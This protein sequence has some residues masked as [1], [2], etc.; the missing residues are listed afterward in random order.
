MRVKYLFVDEK[1]HYKLSA[2]V[3]KQNFN[4]PNYPGKYDP[5]TVCRWTIEGPIGSNIFIEFLNINTETADI[6]QVLVGALTEDFAVMK[7]KIFGVKQNVLYNSFNNYMIIKFFSDHTVSDHTVQRRGFTANYWSQE[8]GLSS[9]VE[10]VATNSQQFLLP[11]TFLSQG[12][13]KV[14]LGH[15]DLVWVIQSK[16]R[17][18]IITLEAEKVSLA[19]DDMIIVYDGDSPMGALLATY[20]AEISGPQYVFSTG[21]KLYIIMRTGDSSHSGEI[22]FS[23]KQG[24]DVTY[25]SDS[26]CVSSPGYPNALYANSQSCTWAIKNPN[27]MPATL[28]FE[29]DWDFEER[30][31]T[32]DYLQVFLGEDG[33]RPE[34]SDE[35]FKSS[36]LKNKFSSDD[37]KFFLRFTTNSVVR[38]KGFKACFSIKCP[39]HSFANTRVLSGSYGIDY[40]SKFK[41]SCA[42]GYFFAQEEFFRNTNEVEM[43]CLINGKWNTRVIPQCMPVFCGRPPLIDHGYLKK[44]EGLTYNMEA[45]YACFP[46][47]NIGTYHTIRCQANAEWQV[48]PTC[49]VAQCPVIANIANGQAEL[50]DGDGTEFGSI[51]FFSCEEGYLIDGAPRILCT[52]EGTWTEPPPTCKR[53]HCILPKIK[54]A[55]FLPDELPGP[56]IGESLTVTCSTGFALSTNS[57]RLTCQNNRTFGLLPS[58]E[59]IDECEMNP[60]SPQSGTCNNTDG[61]FYCTCKEGYRLNE[62]R[63]TCEDINECTMN[64][65]GC[66]VQCQNEIGDYRCDCS[67]KEGHV[68]F[69][70]DGISNYTIPK[71]IETGRMYM[72]VFYIGHTCVRIQCP[73]PADIGNGYI[74][75]HR[76]FNRYTDYIEYH[77]DVGFR[78]VGPKVLQCL[79]TGDWSGQPPVCQ[80][81]TCSPASVPTGLINAPML[82][83][84]DPVPYLGIVN[85]TCNVP[86]KG[87]SVKELKCVYN[88]DS[89][90]YELQGPDYECG[91]IDCKTPPTVTGSTNNSPANTYYDSTYN[92]ACKTLYVPSGSSGDDEGNYVVRCGA[93]GRWH[94]GNLQ[95]IGD[96]CGDPGIP[97]GGRLIAAGAENFE[98][99]GS[100][101]FACD[102]AGFDPSPVS[103]ITCQLNNNGNDLEWNNSA[104]IRCIDT[105]SPRFLSCPQTLQ[106]S[107]YSK[108]GNYLAVPTATDN[109]GIKSFT[110]EPKNANTTFVASD[111]LNVTFTATDYQ[112]NT[113]ECKVSVSI[114]DDEPPS[115][116]CP[117]SRI[118]TITSKDDIETVTFKDDDIQVQSSDVTSIVI[119]PRTSTFSQAHIGTQQEVLV[120]VFDAAQNIAECKFY[121]L[122]KAKVC[123]A[124]YLP[125]P[126][127]GIKTCQPKLGNTGYD[128]TF[129]C[130]EGYA[131][132]DFEKTS[133]DVFCFGD[134]DWSTSVFPACVP[135]NVDVA[136]NAVSEIKYDETKVINMNQEN[137]QAEYKSYID[138]ITPSVVNQLKNTCQQLTQASDDFVITMANITYK[139]VDQFFH[140]TYSITV[141]PNTMDIEKRKTCANTIN[142]I[143]TQS[144]SSL[145]S[146]QISGSTGVCPTVKGLPISQKVMNKCAPG[147]K[148]SNIDETEVC[149]RCP[150]GT[151]V[152]ETGC[153]KCPIGFYQNQRGQTE[154]NKCSTGTSTF[155]E[156]S[157]RAVDCK[158]SCR[159]GLFSTTGLN[160]PCSQCPKNTYSDKSG[161]TQCTSCPT[162]TITVGTGSKS[163]T[164][165][166]YACSKGQFSYNGFEPGCKACPKNFYQDLTNRDDCTECP[167][168]QYTITEGSTSQ[169]DCRNVEADF[170]KIETC[171]HGTCRDIVDV[172]AHTITCQCYKGKLFLV[173]PNIQL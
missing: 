71:K 35:G 129:S 118:V 79:K 43:E 40:R 125:A 80:A 167:K 119:Q 159:P 120:Q 65:G 25:D 67:Q 173:K 141:G 76:S 55:T 46:G 158:P 139:F 108:L 115:F 38:S 86:G 122:V 131:F 132:Y 95:C 37:G 109:F 69:T 133:V 123:S 29:E 30:T 97:V 163:I 63:V 134:G 154:C 102:N 12:A 47:H 87:Q 53:L 8:S 16:Q 68:L 50:H 78:P 83:S 156:G 33:V 105:E 113:A 36:N 164:D 62:D 44:A 49:S 136:V 70:E 82:S 18:Q 28:H 114:K 165:C 172:I 92:F 157:I 52:S 81:T 4:S 10:L 41:I 56:L 148:L 26:G 94:L 140:A 98:E 155:R 19:E 128:C 2:T 116:T 75:S 45:Q 161:Q 130:N 73:D 107:R 88:K 39:D 7:G 3:E 96:R 168:T 74:M 103:S 77:C 51:Y 126:E 170:C 59:D 104:T 149:L 21:T 23:Y 64:N 101:A 143:H 54:H 112:G 100:V 91:F 144:A 22:K 90:V 142:F 1:C 27:N 152:T 57:N 145:E 84:T 171:D 17:T 135:L 124:I 106:V 24:C 66:E 160:E 34:H 150:V 151:R 93:D 60:C 85:M 146:L 166:K 89:D 15:Q 99:G 162:G 110:M 20:T 127:N 137:C 42:R 5:S 31:F 121:I 117:V 48:K 147:D 169:S 138:S 58:C 6:V 72:D 111:D 13:K 14:Y 32:K 9:M 11:P 153:E 61:S